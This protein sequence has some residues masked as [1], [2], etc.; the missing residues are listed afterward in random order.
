M[1][2]AAFDL[3]RQQVEQA[4]TLAKRELPQP[5]CHL[6]APCYSTI[7]R[8]VVVIAGPSGMDD[9]P[10][11]GVRLGLRD[12]EKRAY[13]ETRGGNSTVLSSM[14]PTALTS[15]ITFTWLDPLT[16]P[17]PALLSV[18]QR[19]F[20]SHTLTAWIKWILTRSLLWWL[21]CFYSKNSW[22]FK[23]CNYCTMSGHMRTICTHKYIL[24]FIYTL[25]QF[26]QSTISRKKSK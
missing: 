8:L 15:I 4:G 1:A 21:L 10:S 22:I 5:D 16:S 17:V 6:T 25:N 23:D 26:E 18:P 12:A 14:G 13:N 11:H 3:L 7:S 19:L 9:S 24:E 2:V 20:S